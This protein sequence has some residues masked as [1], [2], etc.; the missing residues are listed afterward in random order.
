MVRAILEGRK[1]QTRRIAKGISIITCDDRSG[2]TDDRC[3]YGVPG[4]LLWVREAWSTDPCYDH[5]MPSRLRTEWPVYY[6]SG[7]GLVITLGFHRVRPSIHMPRWASRLTLEVASIRVERLQEIS[8]GDAKAEGVSGIDEYAH[9]WDSINGVGAWA[10][11]PLVWVVE[12]KRADEKTSVAIAKLA[13]ALAEFD[14]AMEEQ[15]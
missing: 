3:P 1:T 10:L 9:L 5:I 8:D 12:F 4:D 14:R 7:P 15:K 11:N 13:V 2:A 6:D